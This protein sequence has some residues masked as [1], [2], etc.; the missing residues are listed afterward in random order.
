VSFDSDYLDLAIGLAVVFFL[1]SLVVSGL[2]EAFAWLLRRRAKFL[3]AWL[4]DLV[5]TT[6]ELTWKPKDKRPTTQGE[7]GAPGSPADVISRLFGALGPVSPTGAKDKK[8]TIKHIPPSSL[9]QAFLEVFSDLG[10]EKLATNLPALLSA[11]ETERKAG[12]AALGALLAR[13]PDRP[14]AAVTDVFS[15]FAEASA[16]ADADGDAKAAAVDALATALGG[17]SGAQA[18]SGLRDA[19]NGFVGAAADARQQAA[20]PVISALARVF[21]DVLVRERF[22]AS[23]Q[24]LDGTPLGP[25]LKRLWDTSTG[26]M[27]KFRLQFERWLQGELDRL[28]GF[29]KRSI[30]WITLVFVVAVTAVLN[31]DAVAVT[32]SLWRHPEGRTALVGFAQQLGTE[33]ADPSATAAPT[34]TLP[35]DGEQTS[36]APTPTESGL[37]AVRTACELENTSTTAAASGGDTTTATTAPPGSD[38]TTATTA[39]PG[40]DT[41]T[42]TTAPPADDTTTATTAPPADDTTTATADPAAAAK[43]FTDISNCVIDAVNAL[44]GL[45]V[46]DNALVV[47]AGNWADTWSTWGWLWWRHLIGLVGTGA[48]LFLGAPFWFDVVRRITGIRKGVAGD[49]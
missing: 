8:T 1:A 28:G 16:A 49:T 4:Y 43:S 5:S 30:R 42:A 2:N 46:I 40:S 6:S 21:P 7:S 19:V 37:A 23:I 13:P 18:G 26:E 47:N 44:S 33:A 48:A 20:E 12:A 45:G 39:P 10:R 32:Q 3:W 36:A 22:Q 9:A 34:T 14:A 31:I 11:D 17:L 38:T 15:A 27:D 24:S 29:Y 41:T 35:E 25:T